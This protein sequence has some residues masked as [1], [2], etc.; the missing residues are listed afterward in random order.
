MKK[1]LFTILAVTS[2]QITQA[3]TKI[4]I[5]GGANF[6]TYT[7][8]D[9]EN[10][11]M[12]TSFHAGLFAN[13]PITDMIRIQPEV[14]YS[15]Q[16]AK[17]TILDIEFTSKQEYINIPLLLQLKA[18][19]FFAEI[20]PQLGILMSSEISGNGASLDTKDDFTST[21]IAAVL[22]AGFKFESGLGI[23]ARYA[24][25]LTSLDNIDDNVDS[26]VKNSVISLGLLYTFGSK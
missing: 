17:T 9:V 21:D 19:G 5:K 12:L 6:S 26:D 13:L 8:K 20:G 2:L 4:G 15:V 14:V 3:Q 25:G 23:G 7:G 1:L 16:G 24:M 10:A 11:D 22:G 18:S